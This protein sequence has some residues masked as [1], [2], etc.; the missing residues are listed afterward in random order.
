M[1]LGFVDLRQLYADARF[2]VMPLHDVEFQAG[3][4]TILEAMAMGKAV[5]CSRTRGQTDVII[6]GATGVYVP[7]GDAA[8]LR[9][10]IRGLLDDPDRADEIGARG[11]RYVGGGVRRRRLRPPAGGRRR[12]DGRPGG[13]GSR[14]MTDRVVVIGSGPAGANAAREL[15]RRGIPVTMLES[16]TELPGGLLVRAK[17]RNLYR[18][19]ARGP[20]GPGS[21]RDVRPSRDRVV[22]APRARRALQPV[23]RRRAPVRAGGLHRG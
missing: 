9:A 17:G 2:V 4:T 8:A 3:V 1:Q 19:V 22:P 7:P 15:V 16:G 23:D 6:D 14:A 13:E 11:R 18:R 20:L 21:L 5:V 10:A 12:S